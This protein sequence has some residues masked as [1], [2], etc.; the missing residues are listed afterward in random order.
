[1]ASLNNIFMFRSLLVEL[2]V[3]GV[4]ELK[5]PEFSRNCHFITTFAD[6]FGE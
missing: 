3:T 2:D 5:M 4:P 6:I 1:M